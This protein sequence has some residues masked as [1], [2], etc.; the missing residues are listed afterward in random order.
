M[1]TMIRR[2]IIPLLSAY[3]ENQALKVVPLDNCIAS[4]F[5][6]EHNASEGFRSVPVPNVRCCV[7]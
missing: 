3:R 1:N 2:V 6:S 5:L 4:N 7:V